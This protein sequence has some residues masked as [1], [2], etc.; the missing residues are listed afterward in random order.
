MHNLEAVDIVPISG[1]ICEPQL[2]VNA[3]ATSEPII[4]AME[5]STTKDIMMPG[6]K[7]K[8]QDFEYLAGSLAILYIK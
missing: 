5:I 6:S 8:E 7:R 1:I 4:V 2:Q 3:A